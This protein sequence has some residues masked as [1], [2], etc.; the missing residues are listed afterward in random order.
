MSPEQCRAARGLLDLTQTDLAAMADVSPGTL[1]SF[2]KGQ[3]K[4]MKNNVS[5]IRRALEAAG[6]EFIGGNRPG[7]RC[8]K[9]K[10]ENQ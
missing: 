7:V 6:I 2:E 9:I 10:D 5:A 4:P 3:T 8:A 1:R